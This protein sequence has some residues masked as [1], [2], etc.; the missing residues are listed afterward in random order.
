MIKYGVLSVNAQS[1]A[2][3]CK[4][5]ILLISLFLLFYRLNGQYIKTTTRDL[6]LIDLILLYILYI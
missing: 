5:L 3:I 4:N 6:A 2:T 1:K